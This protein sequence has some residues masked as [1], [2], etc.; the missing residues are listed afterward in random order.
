MKYKIQEISQWFVNPGFLIIFTPLLWVFLFLYTKSFIG[1]M[2]FHFWI[3]MTLTVFAL[4]M[5]E[6]IRT[7]WRLKVSCH[8][9]FYI[10]VIEVCLCIR[11]FF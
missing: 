11:V 4:M 9:L 10:S 7:S 5:D 1:T 8:T 6:D 3:G 2:Y